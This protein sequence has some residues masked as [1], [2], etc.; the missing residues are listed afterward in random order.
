MTTSDSIHLGESSTRS[1]DAAASDYS[2]WRNHLTAEQGLFWSQFTMGYTSQQRIQ[3]YLGLILPGKLTIEHD[4][5]LILAH[6]VE[7]TGPW[8]PTDIFIC[9]KWAPNVQKKVLYAP[10]VGFC[11]LFLVV[12]GL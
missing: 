4:G 12:R 5:S 2:W 7:K 1:P 9:G 3:T 11:H 10:E 8:S 6:P